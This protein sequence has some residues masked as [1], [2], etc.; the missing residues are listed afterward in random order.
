MVT[1]S[2]PE[3]VRFRFLGPLKEFPHRMAGR[4]SQ[5][6]YSREMAF[7]AR[8]APGGAGTPILGV[9]R[10]L[11]DPDN[12][13]AEFAIMVRSDLKGRGL[14]YALMTVLLAYARR[15]GLKVVHGDVLYE[16][17]T[18]LQMADEL[19]FVRTAGPDATVVSVAIDLT[20]PPAGGSSPSV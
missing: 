10:L 7:V 16:N 2:S 3:D 15:K 6:D 20:K 18:M 11:A 17:R 5:I 8:E 13:D 1:R 4:L 9:A 12:E 19:G 14:G